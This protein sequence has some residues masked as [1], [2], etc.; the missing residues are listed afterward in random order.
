MRIERLE[1]RVVDRL[2]YEGGDGAGVD[3]VFDVFHVTLRTVAAN[4]PQ[5]GGRLPAEAAAS[6][7]A[8]AT[9]TARRD[10]NSH[11]AAGVVLLVAPFLQRGG[12]RHLLLAGAPQ[13]NFLLRDVLVARHRVR[14]TDRLRAAELAGER[15][16]V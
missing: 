12:L 3:V 4:E 10:G 7:T 5:L 2:R 15:I 1:V 13:P 9:A 11:R 8:R 14:L 6:L 16:D